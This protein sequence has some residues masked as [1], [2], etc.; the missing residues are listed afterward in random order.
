MFRVGAG[1]KP[2]LGCD[3][4]RGLNLCWLFPPI[5]QNAS[6]FAGL[7]IDADV[8]THEVV[9]SLSFSLNL[10]ITGLYATSPVPSLS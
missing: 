7:S 8:V 1:I 10:M 5:F 3:L 4:G 9:D 2:T 6:A